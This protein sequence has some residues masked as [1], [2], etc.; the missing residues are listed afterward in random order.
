MGG[1]IFFRIDYGHNSSNTLF[2]IERHYPGKVFYVYNFKLG[3][4]RIKGGRVI[5]R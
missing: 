1:V 3:K 2:T 4:K 5:K